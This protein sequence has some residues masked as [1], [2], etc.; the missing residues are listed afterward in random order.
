MKKEI[1]N[2]CCWCDYLTCQRKNK[3]VRRH[4]KVY[5]DFV[6]GRLHRKHLRQ[7]EKSETKK[8]LN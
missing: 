6:K 8:E 7:K 3:R 4:C 2:C 5:K 1:I